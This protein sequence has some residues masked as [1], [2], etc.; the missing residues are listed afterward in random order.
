M[1]AKFKRNDVVYLVADRAKESRPKYRILE[2]FLGS[3]PHELGTHKGW[4]VQTISDDESEH[5]YLIVPV[6]GGDDRSVN[7]N[8]IEA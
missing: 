5:N 3:V 7:E 2:Y 6:D 1:D 8:E 4:H